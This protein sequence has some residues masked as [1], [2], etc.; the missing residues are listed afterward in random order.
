MRWTGVLLMVAGCQFSSMA[1]PNTPD[2]AAGD[3][4]PHGLGMFVTWRANPTIPGTLSDNL[5]VSDATFQIDRL[6]IVAEA[7]NVMRT[8]S[9]LAWDST[10]TPQEENFPGAPPGMYSRVTLVMM[11]GGYGDYAYQIH[12]TW[13]DTSPPKNFEIRDNTALSIGLNCSAML[14][15]AG[16]ATIGLKVD[17]RD[18]LDG[19]DFKSL[20]E[21]DGVLELH[22]GQALIDF[23]GR[24]MNAFEL[25]N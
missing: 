23:R 9:L 10:A 14:A 4:R 25:D 16:S 11:P 15:A 12:G 7:G 20:D 17:L 24:L 21:E 2:A 13:R 8:R 3:G 19:I 6:Q 18:A 22:D 5:T 1:G